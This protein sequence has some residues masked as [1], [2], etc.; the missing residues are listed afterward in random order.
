MIAKPRTANLIEIIGSGYATINQ[1]LWVILFPFV[2]ALGLW[3][4]P[5]VALVR[6]LPNNAPLLD[7]LEQTIGDPTW[8][9]QIIGFLAT[10]DLR[11]FSVWFNRIPLFGPE[12]VPNL[13]EPP[14]SLLQALNLLFSYH[15]AGIGLSGVYLT[16]LNRAL[17]ASEPT[18]LTLSWESLRTIF[19][20]FFMSGVMLIFI[21]TIS[22][23]AFGLGLLLW[24]WMP[25]FELL[26]AFLWY[27]IIFW[28]SIYTSF[29]PEALA[30]NQA[31]PLN[32]L[33]LS[34]Q[35]VRQHFTA[36]LVLLAISSLI[37]SGCHILLRQLALSQSWGLPVACLGSAYLGSGLAAA[38]MEFF[39][40]RFQ[41]ASE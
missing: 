29:A 15:L 35:F 27:I 19:G 23:L 9:G 1:H 36:C 5:P 33:H 41:A 28:A 40:H 26:I 25:T 3:Y 39:R 24:Y 18:I 17:F 13:D 7:Q 8:R 38:R 32:G 10:S 22:L 16:L 6:L 11:V 30:Q 2:F 14:V 34:V 31:H 4:T 20:L 12:L 21:A 37:T